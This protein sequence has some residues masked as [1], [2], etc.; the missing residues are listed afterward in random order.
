MKSGRTTLPAHVHTLIVGAGFG[1]IGLAATLLREDPTA[2]LLVIERADDVGGTW[3]DNTYP[4]CACDVPTALYSYSFAPEPGWRYA[5]GKQ[6]EIYGYLRRV[7]DETGVTGR[8]V[9][10]CELIE[11]QWDAG[12]R[13]WRVHTGRGTLTATVLVAA[14]G[15]LS[16][17]KRPDVPGVESFAGTAFHSAT[18]DHGYDLAGKRV[19]VIGTG[20]SAIQFVPEIVD[21]VEHLTLFQR[22]ASWVLPKH[23]RPISRFERALFRALPSSQKLVRGAVYAQKEGYVLGMAH[24]LWL[25]RLFQ[26]RAE[27]Y[28]R[29]QVPDDGL[30]AALTPTFTI[31]CKRIL[32]SNDWLRTLTRR[33]VTV[34]SSGLTAVT[35]NGVIDDLGNEYP[36]DAIIFATGFTPT[37][38]PVAR[39]VR[40]ADGRTLAEHW[41]GSPSAHLGTTVHGFPNLFLM[42]GPNTNLGH[43]SIVYMLESQAAYIADALRVMR[44][45]RAATA[46]V[47]DGAQRRY[48]EQLDPQLARTVWNAGGCDSW[49]L[50][51]SGRNSVMWPTFTWRFRRRTRRF[52]QENYRF[53]AAGEGRREAEDAGVGA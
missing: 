37:E 16:A 13:Q 28:L 47:T 24:Q 8:T 29:A 3:R 45:E 38:P 9:T 43:S 23:D 15:A 19:A 2:D 36:V 30:R 5:Y 22:T 42:Y 20:A 44:A 6:D 50:D 25:L 32:L 48:N 34:V 17:P 41:A 26:R 4:G 53:T 52:D 14:T 51:R 1:G 10:G 18:W 27:A 12:H 31:T 40:G 46:E 35:E 7:A 33:D 49:Y 11:A 21:R 39:H